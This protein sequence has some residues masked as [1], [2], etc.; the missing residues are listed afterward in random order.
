[1]AAR[2]DFASAQWKNYKH[3]NS[4]GNELPRGRNR[5]TPW[6]PLKKIEKRN[7]IWDLQQTRGG[8]RIITDVTCRLGNR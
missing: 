6:R 5:G 2:K 4:E 7:T 8:R 1:M 3:R